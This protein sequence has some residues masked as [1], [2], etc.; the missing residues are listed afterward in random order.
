MSRLLLALSVN[1]FLADR[2][3]RMMYSV[4]NQ[5]ACYYAGLYADF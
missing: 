2:D 3:L 4:I 1:F 5:I